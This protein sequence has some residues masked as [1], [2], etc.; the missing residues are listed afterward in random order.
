MLGDSTSSVGAESAVVVGFPT[1]IATVVRC[2]AAA[3]SALDKGLRRAGCVAAWVRISRRLRRF[4]SGG[5]R[6]VREAVAG[7]RFRWRAGARERDSL[8]C[9]LNS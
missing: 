5:W 9:A 6:G 3:E 1:K 8:H 2:Q 7:A 4:G